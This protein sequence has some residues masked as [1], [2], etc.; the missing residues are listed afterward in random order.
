MGKF[1]EE[2]K[3]INTLFKLFCKKLELLDYAYCCSKYLY[4][5]QQ[6]TNK[7]ATMDMWILAMRE[8]YFKKE[9]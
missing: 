2:E 3:I 4:K 5:F 6:S 1:I 9:G 8:I 7:K